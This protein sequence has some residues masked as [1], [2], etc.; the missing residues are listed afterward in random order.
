MLQMD[1]QGVP[2]KIVIADHTGTFNDYENPLD[3]FI[4]D[5][6]RPVLSRAKK[7]SDAAAFADAY[8]NAFLEK[9]TSMQQEYREKRRA[10]DTFFQHSKQGEK[11]FAWRWAKVL[12]RLDKTNAAA[13]TDKIR[14]TIFA[15][16]F[17]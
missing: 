7:V 13:L 9:M 2:L 10:F 16:V 8:L 6:A 14:Q 15:K 11:T 12:A 17:R 1:E 3:K 5:Y 4:E